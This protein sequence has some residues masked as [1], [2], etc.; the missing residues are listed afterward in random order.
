MAYR[1]RGTRTLD[2]EPDQPDEP[3]I[4]GH[5]FD[6]AKCGT[7][8]GYRQ[9][10]KFGEPACRP[11]KDGTAAYHREQRARQAKRKAAA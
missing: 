6:P 2:T 7:N 9:H 3:F 5:P 8:A 4:G 1:Y 10:Q 11:C